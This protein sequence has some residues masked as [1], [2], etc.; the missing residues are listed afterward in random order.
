LSGCGGDAPAQPDNGHTSQKS[1]RKTSPESSS[2]ISVS[3]GRSLDGLPEPYRSAD[4][5]LGRRT[6]KLCSAC[7]TVTEGGQNLVGPNLHGIF[8]R[9]VGTLP[10]F[11]YS[12]ALEEADFLWTPDH[13]DAWLSNPKSYLPGNNMSFVGVRK[14]ADRQAV[15]AYL[16]LESGYDPDTGSELP[17]AAED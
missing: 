9:E 10:G 1:E 4:Y 15:I 14:P 11:R 7:H 13:V 3:A 2:N 5:S 12:K 17:V 16:M 8:S 6:F